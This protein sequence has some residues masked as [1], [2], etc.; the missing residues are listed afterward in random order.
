MITE[1]NFLLYA[2]KN[3]D[4]KNCISHDEFLDDLNRIKY[5][6]KL[7]FAFRK[8]GVLRERLIL[9]HLV[10]LY[11]VFEVKACTK[12]L[13]FKLDEYQEYLKPFLLYL[14][15][16]PEVLILNETVIYTTDIALDPTIISK[17]REIEQ[18]RKTV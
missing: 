7:F 15:Y 14:G 10:I 9:N 6:K 13:F 2:S 4:N 1:E 17:L 18:E 5:L 11:N 12:M 8:K 16:L 3:Y